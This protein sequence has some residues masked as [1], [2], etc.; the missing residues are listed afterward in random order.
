MPFFY[1]ERPEAEL[2]LSYEIAETDRSSGSST[3]V[4]EDR[5]ISRGE[6]EITTRG[7]V[8][9]P[10]LLEFAAGIAPKLVRE[11]LEISDGAGNSTSSEN[12]QDFLGYFVDATFLQYKP[13]SLNLYALEDQRDYRTSLSANTA[14]ETKVYRGV[15]TLSHTGMS[16]ALTT[17]S[18][19]IVTEGLTD[20]DE[21]LDTLRLESSAGTQRSNVRLRAENKNQDRETFALVGSDIESVRTDSDTF[22]AGIAHTY[23]FTPDALL[24]TDFTHRDTLSFTQATT[25][26]QQEIDTLLSRF[27]SR[28]NIQHRRNFRSYYSVQLDRRD[29]TRDGE[30]FEFDSQFASAGLS[31][32]LYENLTT[33]L[34]VDGYQSDASTGEFESYRANLDFR[35]DRRI[36]WGNLLVNLGFEERRENDQRTI[37]PI[38][39]ENQALNGTELAFFDNFNVVINNTPTDIVVTDVTGVTRYI[40]GVDYE[41]TTFDENV[42]DGNLVATSVAI[43]R[44]PF[45]NIADGATVL[46][47]YRFVPAGTGKSEISTQRFGVTLDLWHTLRVYYYLQEADEDV[48]SGTRP[49]VIDDT[50]QRMGAELRVG[51]STT[52]VEYEDQ[53]TLRNPFKRTRA[54]EVVFFQPHSRL[55][56]SLTAYWSQLHKVDT[57]EDQNDTGGSMN[58][59]WNTHG[60]A[61]LSGYGLLERSRGD[62]QDINRAGIST[63]YEWRW[64]AWEPSITYSWLDEE[65]TSRQTAYTR[66]NLLFKITREF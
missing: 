65:F 17:E 45:G 43:S 55:S 27:S 62:I 23:Q 46:V 33:T 31:H 10:A 44:I 8:Y 18:R 21:Q 24:T 66:N 13:Y 20:S 11:D 47:D 48:K 25:L 9:H 51:P 5:N 2:E 26:A 7:W 54:E 29:D 38:I 56:L 6:L 39:D 36:P 32:L 4:H 22:D 3:E 30:R 60:R 16:S 40:E 42:V 14:T 63:S 49:V 52:R 19:E 53:D 12:N 37:T 1:V 61:Y 50:I 58:F 41:V 28:L 34:D 64:G 57:R 35:Y 59:R 15:M